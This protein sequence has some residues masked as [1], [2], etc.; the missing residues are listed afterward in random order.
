MTTAIIDNFFVNPQTKAIVQGHLDILFRRDDDTQYSLR[1]YAIANYGF[2]I[3]CIE[4]IETITS[5]SKNILEVGSGTGY[6]S[7]LLRSKVDHLICTDS[8]KNSYRFRVGSQFRV[9]HV[10]AVK[11]IKRY[12]EK[13][14]LMSWPCYHRNWSYHAAKAMKPGRYLFYIGEGAYGCTGTDEFHDYLSSDKFQ[15]INSCSIP[16]WYGLHDRL[17][18][19]QKSR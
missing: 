16:K 18:I 8:G 15:Y 11:A 3:P 12:P 6:L 10:N 17:E 13:D 19:Y 9:I 4:L 2:A 7:K 14:V 5:F 1:K